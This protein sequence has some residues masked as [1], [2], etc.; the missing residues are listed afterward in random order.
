MYAKTVIE[1]RGHEFEAEWEGVWRMWRE[2]RKG[3]NVVVI[4]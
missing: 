4:L 3:R 2:E 1:K